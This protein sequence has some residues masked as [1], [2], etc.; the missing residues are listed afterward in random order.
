MS[1]ETVK[2]A[3]VTDGKLR[4]WL[5]DDAT[6]SHEGHETPT[7]AY[8]RLRGHKYY[9]AQ[10]VEK[11]DHGDWC[12]VLLKDG[13]VVAFSPMG[14]EVYM[15]EPKEM[16]EQRSRIRALESTNAALV[17]E[18]ARLREALIEVRN[19]TDIMGK[20]WDGDLAMGRKDVMN[21]GDIARAALEQ[22]KEPQ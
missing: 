3:S 17:A 15:P 2:P 21:M 1:N 11:E 22:P 6:M 5:E 20:Y 12:A 14:G 7:R 13:W 8:E 10:V 4:I 9:P 16:V 19:R 18:C